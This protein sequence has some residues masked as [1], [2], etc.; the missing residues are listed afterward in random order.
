MYGKVGVGYRLFNDVIM[1]HVMNERTVVNDYAIIK[2]KVSEFLYQPIIENVD[3]YAIKRSV[4]QQLL[5]DPWW[6]RFV[7]LWVKTYQRKIQNIVLNHRL[8]MTNKFK[9]R[10]DYVDLGAFG[11]ETENDKHDHAKLI[12]DSKL[13]D[14]NFII[15]KF[16][17]SGGVAYQ[18]D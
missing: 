14:F 17:Q 7:P 12:H 8:D 4:F 9:N 10:I 5:E 2:N 15:D 3:G 18:L 6:K 16:T 1:G 11:V 13:D